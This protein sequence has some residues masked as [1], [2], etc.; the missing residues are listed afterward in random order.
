MK[1]DAKKY[2]DKLEEF[3]WYDYKLI[4]RVRGEIDGSR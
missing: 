4:E 3:G 1:E 2:L